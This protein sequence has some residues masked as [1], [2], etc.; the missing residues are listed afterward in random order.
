MAISET[1]VL[2]HHIE[3]L[4]R[5]RAVSNTVLVR[6]HEENSNLKKENAELKRQIE[7]FTKAEIWGDDAN[8]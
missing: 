8:G 6:L 1:K 4:K 3:A 7:V 2:E 5:Y